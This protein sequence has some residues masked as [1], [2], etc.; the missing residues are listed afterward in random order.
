MSAPL[1]IT[2]GVPNA[3]A[4]A[5]AS[6][7]AA[8]RANSTYVGNNY[9]PNYRPNYNCRAPAIATRV[10]SSN[11]SNVIATKF[12]RSVKEMN[13]HVFQCYEE[14][15]TKNQYHRTIEELN[16]YVGITYCILETLKNDQENG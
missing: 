6:D 1:A 15:T 12:T 8:R 13:G 9:D 14:S 10:P 11:A 2:S 3:A 5:S 4:P 16:G 7:P